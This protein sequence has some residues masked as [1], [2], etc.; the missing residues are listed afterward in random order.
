[1][2][3]GKIFSR[4]NPNQT[5]NICTAVGVGL[6]GALSAALLILK[7]KYPLQFSSPWVQRSAYLL[8]PVA[9]A[10]AGLRGALLYW[11]GEASSMQKTL[12]G[13]GLE[14]ELLPT[15]ESY[16]EAVEAVLQKHGELQQNRRAAIGEHP[17]KWRD[18]QVLALWRQE[19]ELALCAVDLFLKS[20]DMRNLKRDKGIGCEIFKFDGV[21]LKTDGLGIRAILSVCESYNEARRVFAYGGNAEGAPSSDLE[22]LGG[23]YGPFYQGYKGE[24]LKLKMHQSY[25]AFCERVQPYLNAALTHEGLRLIATHTAWLQ[26]DG[27]PPMEEWLPGMPPRLKGG[28]V[29]PRRSYVLPTGGAAQFERIEA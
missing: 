11:N 15:P 13:P 14:I 10:C 29:L 26:Q 17:Y 27:G 6:C 2:E 25:N 4:D 16:Q 9:L 20:L 24:T 23:F 21:S 8:P 12:R 19:M 5:G 28:E 7:R 18:E 22:T 3:V 1:M